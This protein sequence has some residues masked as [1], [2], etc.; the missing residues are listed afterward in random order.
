M[1]KLAARTEK[2]AGHPVGAGID[3]GRVVIAACNEDFDQIDRADAPAPEVP[4]SVNAIAELVEHLGGRVW[5]ISKCGER[6]EARTRRWLE[7]RKFHE[8]T[9]LP[10]NHVCFCRNRGDKA[11][12]AASLG[13]D[14][15]VDDRPDV[16]R[17]MRGIVDRLI[18]F[19][20]S[21]GEKGI[22]P[23]PGWDVALDLLLRRTWY[24]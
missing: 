4:G 10:P 19:G 21:Q 2:V 1:Q 17:P 20:A 5:L 16:L 6:M 11:G 13:I 8:R 15:F 12:I 24:R 23:A 7:L 14:R 9:R 18:L 3:I 22:V